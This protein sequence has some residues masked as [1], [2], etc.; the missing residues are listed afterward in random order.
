M[1]FF[2]NTQTKE[3]PIFLGDVQITHPDWD[4]NVENPPTHLVWV[5][6]A[7]IE[8]QED[9]IIEDAEPKQIN[10]VWIRQYTVRDLN[11][12]EKARKDAPKT[13][14]AKLKALGLSDV[15]IEALSQG[16]IR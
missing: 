2:Y 12:A 11:A 9:K 16:L 10:G 5:E 15:E 4:G 1:A 7:A 8:W 3:F 14:K 13:A 6:D